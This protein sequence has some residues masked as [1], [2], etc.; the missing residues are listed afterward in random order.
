MKRPERLRSQHG[1]GDWTLPPSKRETVGLSESH[2]FTQLFDFCY[3]VK[4]PE[5]W[6]VGH[7]VVIYAV[8]EC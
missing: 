4:H 3:M 7:P 2:T 8:I 6:R 1:D 5:R